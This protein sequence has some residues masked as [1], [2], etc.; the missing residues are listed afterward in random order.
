[1]NESLGVIRVA[2]RH[3]QALLSSET[4]W[5]ISPFATA[6]LS[7]VSGHHLKL[8]VSSDGEITIED[9]SRHGTYV[10][11]R[12]IAQAICV[13][14]SCTLIHR[15]QDKPVVLEHGDEIYLGGD[16]ERPDAV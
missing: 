8:A 12:R 4:D 10:N 16:G 7:L 6:T 2:G 3:S 9:K 11:K 1:M 13:F 14:P 15:W 5:L